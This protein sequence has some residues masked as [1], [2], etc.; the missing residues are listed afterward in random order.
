MRIILKTVVTVALHT[1]CVWAAGSEQD[2]VAAVQRVFDSMAAKDAQALSAAFLPD[3]RLVALSPDG[4][5]TST[6][7][8]EWNARISTMQE[9]PLERIWSPKVLIDGSLATL[10]APYD[11]HR[12]GKFSHCG[13]DQVTL[14]RQDGVWKVAAL[15][16]TIQREGCQPSPLGPPKP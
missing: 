3:A 4:R 2:V 6:P 5:V 14:V 1:I 9:T 15:A 13:T 10:W 11:F 8:A 7:A 16:Y 12:G